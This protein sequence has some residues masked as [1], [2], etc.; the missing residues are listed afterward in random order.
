MSINPY[1]CPFRISY[2]VGP[3]LMQKQCTFCNI[4]ICKT[5]FWNFYVK[6]KRQN[7]RIIAF[8]S[9]FCEKWAIGT[10]IFAK[11]HIFRVFW[12]FLAIL[13]LFVR[14][15]QFWSTDHNVL[16]LF[17]THQNQN[18]QEQ[19]RKF[20]KFMLIFDENRKYMFAIFL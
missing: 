18:F 15:E 4:F 17:W 11:I 6:Q 8:E 20:R 9:D 13:E 2:Q 1:F 14:S 10:L 7:S 12:P 5:R 3:D 16:V 19:I